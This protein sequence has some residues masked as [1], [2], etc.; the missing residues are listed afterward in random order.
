MKE[1]DRSLRRARA[2][3]WGWGPE[4][5]VLDNGAWDRGPSYRK[6]SKAGMIKSLTKALRPEKANIALGVNFPTEVITSSI[7]EALELL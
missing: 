3:N 4:A 7:C 6:A 1:G 5:G 2:E